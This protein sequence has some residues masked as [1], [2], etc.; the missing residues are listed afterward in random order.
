MPKFPAPRDGKTTS[1]ATRLGS[2]PSKNPFTITFPRQNGKKTA[3]PQIPPQTN[4]WYNAAGM[5]GGGISTPSRAM[6]PDADSTIPNVKLAIA[7]R[8]PAL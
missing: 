7:P 3:T 6:I 8:D 1:P 2:T 5:G 4:L